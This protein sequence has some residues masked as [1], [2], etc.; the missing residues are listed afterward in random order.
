MEI[1]IIGLTE[2]ENKL[3]NLDEKLSKALAEALDE[4]SKKIRDDAK[5]FAP[6]DTGS[7]RKSIRTEKKGNLEASIIAG[8]GGLVNPRTGR[9]VDYAGYVEYGTSRM[10]PQPYMQPALEKNMNEILQIVKEKIL[11]VFR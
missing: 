8:G 3:S 10:S 1:E 11:E 7:L 5:S 6:V 2:L 9:E 4:I